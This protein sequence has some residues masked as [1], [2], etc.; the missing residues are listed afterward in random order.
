MYDYSHPRLSSLPLRLSRCLLVFVR[1][2]IFSFNLMSN[3]HRWHWRNS[4]V[5]GLPSHRLTDRLMLY[6]LQLW[7]GAQGSVE[8]CGVTSCGSTW[9]YASVTVYHPVKPRGMWSIQREGMID[10]MLQDGARRS[11]R[12]PWG[13]WR[14][15]GVGRPRNV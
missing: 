13:T 6:S 12:L 9:H 10:H 11:C 4:I 2:R 1:C 14:L 8:E 7:S 5:F 15:S 3:S